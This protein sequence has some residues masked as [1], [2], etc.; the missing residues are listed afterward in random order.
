MLKLY[1]EIGKTMSSNNIP[2]IWQF[3]NYTTSTNSW[4]SIFLTTNL[5]KN[6]SEITDTMTCKID[7]VEVAGS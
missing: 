5:S 7:T 4:F 3:Q 6:E 1:F 2:I